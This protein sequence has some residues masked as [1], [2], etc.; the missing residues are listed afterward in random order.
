MGTRIGGLYV[1]QGTN[2][3]SIEAMEHLTQWELEADAGVD[4]QLETDS[5]RVIVPGPY[6]ALA[7]LSFKGEAGVTYYAEVRVNG[8]R[9][10]AG[11]FAAQTADV[12]DSIYN[13]SLIGAGVL[14]AGDLVSIYVG[15]NKSGGASFQLIYG[16]FGLFSD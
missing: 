3:N 10:G 9:V 16:Q 12:A 5:I 15:S 8:N 1:F 6:K 7:S 14:N 11:I 2:V 4:G 13:M